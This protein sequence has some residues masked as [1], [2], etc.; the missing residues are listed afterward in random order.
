VAAGVQNALFA[1]TSSA[2]PRLAPAE[3]YYANV[4]TGR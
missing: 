3:V 1:R 2:P 4:L